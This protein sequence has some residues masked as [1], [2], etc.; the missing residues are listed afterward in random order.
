MQVPRPLQTTPI[1][2]PPAIVELS[3]VSALQENIETSRTTF[4]TS[5]HPIYLHNLALSIIHNLQYHHDWS[6]LTVHTHSGSTNS[7]LP[8][9]VI[10]GLPPKRA[11]IHP[12]E[13]VEILKAEHKSGKSIEQVPEREWVLPT[14]LEEKWSLAKFAAVFNALDTVPPN[15]RE[16]L[17]G[18]EAEIVGHQWRG[19]NRQKRL[20]L[21]TLHDDSIVVYYII[22]DGIVKPRQN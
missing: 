10:S 21:A 15:G 4:Q 13:Q 1:M 12:D 6:S 3:S 11:Y 5:S 9:P 17:A 22:H 16:T 18:E 2:A 19:K 7:P 20:L 8:R 14:H